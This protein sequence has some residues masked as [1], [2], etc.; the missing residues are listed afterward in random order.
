MAN[1]SWLIVCGLT[2]LLVSPIVLAE[3]ALVATATSAA[4]ALALDGEGSSTWH[5]VKVAE[6]DLSTANTTGLILTVTGDGLTKAGGTLIAVQLVTVE[7][8]QIPTA[9]DFTIPA[10]SSY[11]FSTTQAGSVDR[12]LFIRYQPSSLQDP[13]TYTETLQLT[14]QDNL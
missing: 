13:G 14:V 10:G 5:I 2:A 6:V 4:T 8:G 1:L 11:V 3:P 12:D 7:H 9:S